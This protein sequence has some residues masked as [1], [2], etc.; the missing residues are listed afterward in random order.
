MC[1]IKCLIVTHTIVHVNAISN[2]AFNTNISGAKLIYISMLSIEILMYIVRSLLYCCLISLFPLS[3]FPLG[4][5]ARIFNSFLRKVNLKNKKIIRENN[6]YT[7]K[8]RQKSS[9]GFLFLDLLD[10]CLEREIQPDLENGVER[11]FCISIFFQLIRAV[12]DNSE[13]L[14]Y[15]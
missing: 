13:A 2:V 15:S 1:D 6:R 4:K 10:S 9:K 7:M 12:S 3:T 5:T 11:A 14:L 8:L